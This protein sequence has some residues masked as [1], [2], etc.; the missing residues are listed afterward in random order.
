MPVHPYINYPGT[1]REALEC[2]ARAFGTG[3]AHILTHGDRPP[4]PGHPVTDTVKGLAL[5]SRLTIHGTEVMFADATPGTPL[6]VGDSITMMVNDMAP[7]AIDQ[8]FAVLA[9]SGTVLTSPQNTFWS[10]RYAQLVDRYGIG[11]Q[12]SAER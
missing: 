5:H 9:E 1:C 10:E 12:L 3:P 11:W 7:K 4:E 8:A 6:N 2:Y